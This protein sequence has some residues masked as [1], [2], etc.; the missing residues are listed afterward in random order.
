MKT[1]ASRE[2]DSGRGN[3]VNN[4]TTSKFYRFPALSTTAIIAQFRAAL[5]TRSIIAP[6]D[7]VA[8]GRLHR[9]DAEGK[10]GKGDAAYLLHLDGIPAGGFEN[11]RDG[12]GWQTWRA[13]I[14]RELSREEAVAC[15]SRIDAMR[16]EREAEDA[17]R[18]AKARDRAAAIWQAAKPVINH[19]Y[20]TRKGVRA[21]GLRIQGDRLI[22]PI[23]DACGVLHGLQFIGPDGTKR[24]LKGG[25][26]RGCFHAIGVLDHSTAVIVCEGYATGASIHEAT[27]YVVVV[28]FD[29]GN[30]EAVARALK[31]KYPDARLVI[32]ADNDRATLATLASA[33]RGKPRLR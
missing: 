5:A 21:H 18:K 30:L 8:D 22:V 12:L 10:H 17:Q 16:R 7:F 9:C 19:S 29:C 28:A 20:L 33:R 25:R 13:D 27:D 2:F 32:A 31:A 1:P 6:A 24:F 14:G 3:A 23:H 26:V 11:H 4:Q 15:Q